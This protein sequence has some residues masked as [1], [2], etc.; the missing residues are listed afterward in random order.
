MTPSFSIRFT[1]AELCRIMEAGEG[2][3]NYQGYGVS[4]G[5]MRTKVA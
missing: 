2:D 4:Y 5:S 3:S 1:V